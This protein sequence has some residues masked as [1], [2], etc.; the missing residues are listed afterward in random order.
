MP[1]N[2]TLYIDQQTR[3]LTFDADGGLITVS[4]SATTA[5][6]VRDVLMT[7]LDEYEL[8]DGHGTNYDRIQGKKA[9]QLSKDETFDVIRE[10]IFQEPGVKE[11]TRLDADLNGRELRITFE[12]VLTSGESI[13]LEVST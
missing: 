3:D 4:G 11:V 1:G 8:A 5:Q 9:S 7:Y 12:G 10:A 6:C 2:T 13:E